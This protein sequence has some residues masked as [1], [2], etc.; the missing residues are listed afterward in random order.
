MIGLK[1][2]RKVLLIMEKERSSLCSGNPRATAVGDC[3]SV[4]RSPWESNCMI[5]LENHVLFL[6]L[7]TSAMVSKE[8]SEWR[9]CNSEGINS[10]HKWRKIGLSDLPPI[11]STENNFL[12]SLTWLCIP[13]CYKLHVH[14]EGSFQVLLCLAFRSL[15]LPFLLVKKKEKIQK[16]QL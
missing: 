13:P 8:N 10:N 6:F 4:A 12:Q 1:F 11:R 5:W 15:G 3:D 9:G 2:P 7:P 16:C 14:G